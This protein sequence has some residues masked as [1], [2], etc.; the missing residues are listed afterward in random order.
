MKSRSLHLSLFFALGLTLTNCSTHNVQRVSENTVTDLSGR[1]N[2]TDSR[3][4]AEEITAEL[5]EHSWYST[6]AS[7]NAGK[8]P[9][10]IVGMIV[11]KSHEHIAVETFSK[12]IEKAIINSGRM[13]LVQAGNMREEIRGERADQQNFASQST[14]KKF[15]LENGADFM[16]Q[17]TVNSIVDQ[18]SKEKTVYYQVDLE[19]SNIQ[20][21][22]KVW[23]GD[24]KIKKYIGKKL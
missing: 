15:G 3:L 2:E 11:N 23:I 6:Y 4:T 24:K 18:Y 1:W 21:N 19:L 22:E 13:K 8:K 14:M 20:T 9:V 17:G 5:M 7:D 16:L 10:I 12:D